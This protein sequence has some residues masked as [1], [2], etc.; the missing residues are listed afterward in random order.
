[1]FFFKIQL[2]YC[3]PNGC[4]I[5]FKFLKP[6][7]VHQNSQL[8]TIFYGMRNYLKINEVACGINKPHRMLM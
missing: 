7:Q 6:K 3:K 5:V 4:V 1:M 8:V 2:N